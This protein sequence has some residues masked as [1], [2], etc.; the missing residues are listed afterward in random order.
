[1]VHY[2]CAEPPEGYLQEY[3]SVS[4]PLC[5]TDSSTIFAHDNNDFNVSSDVKRI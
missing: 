2:K 5:I 3:I 4:L 1:M